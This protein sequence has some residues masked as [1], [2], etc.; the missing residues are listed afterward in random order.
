MNISNYILPLIVL[1]I[2]VYGIYKKVD[3]FN[4]FIDTTYLNLFYEDIFEKYDI[5]HVILYKNSKMNLMISNTNDGKYD[6]LYED[7][8]FTIYEIKEQPINIDL[9]D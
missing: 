1:I 2:V 6:C 5:T 8:Y 4:D 7:D 9:L 3:I